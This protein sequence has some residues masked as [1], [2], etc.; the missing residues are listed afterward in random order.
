MSQRL[1][2]L[3]VVPLNAEFSKNKMG[4]EYF[5]KTAPFWVHIC[6]EY[7]NKK[8]CLWVF[9]IH[10]YVFVFIVTYFY[11]DCTI[12]LGKHIVPAKL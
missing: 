3:A 4:P 10:C 9:C 11:I 2:G 6:V 5:L 8:K 1:K 12:L 7:K